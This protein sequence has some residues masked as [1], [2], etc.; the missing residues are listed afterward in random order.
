[1][2]QA[3]ILTH[4]SSRI[5]VLI[6]L[7]TKLRSYSLFKCSCQISITPEQYKTIKNWWLMERK[8]QFFVAELSYSTSSEA[9]DATKESQYPTWEIWGTNLYSNCKFW[10]CQALQ[11]N[12]I[13][14]AYML[15]LNYMSGSFNSK[16]WFNQN[17]IKI[18]SIWACK[19]VCLDILLQ[20]NYIIF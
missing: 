3:I 11:N 20:I 6:L 1:M 9:S 13:K 14:S 16:P 12:T 17:F 19:E 10:I 5:Q 7:K 15:I 8:L 2:L 4:L 18:Y